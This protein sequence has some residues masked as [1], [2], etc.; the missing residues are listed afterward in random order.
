[1]GTTTR[2]R[3][4]AGVLVAVT[5]IGLAT[6]IVF[7]LR[8]VAP[9]V[10]LGVVYLLAVLLVA[11]VWGLW[12]GFA[13]AL[14]SALAFNFFHIPHTGRLTVNEGENWVALAVFLVAAAVSSSLAERARTR[15][16]EAE[17][18]RRE[19][20]LALELARLLLRGDD[21]KGSLP[22]ASQQLAAALGVTCEIVLRRVEPDGEHLVFALREGKR[23]LGTLLLPKAADPLVR[24]RV[25]RRIV[26]S[27]EALLAAA[28][29]R[30]ELLTDVV[31]TRALR[32]SD[33]VKTALLRAVSHDLRSPLTAILTAVEP[34]A[35]EQVE[36]ADRRELAR[37]VRDE[38]HRLSRLIDQLLDLSKLEADAADPRPEW[39]SVEEVVRAAMHDLG[40]A[41]D[42]F[43]VSLDKDTPLVR[44][45]A[46]QLERAFANVLENSLRYANGHPVLVRGGGT[47]NRVMVR[48]V[49]R[50]PGMLPAQAERI[51]EPFYRSGAEGTGHRGSGLGLAIARGFLEA[52]GGR[53]WAESQAGHETT[54]VIELPLAAPARRPAQ[55]AG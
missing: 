45:D 19:A 46:A 25:E 34:L 24:E 39:V 10:S 18:H 8:D 3:A 6:L 54:F 21:L 22:A 28:L 29:E 12:L 40:A 16:D 55:V 48:I 17:D 26:P 33:V 13:T 52:N 37:D 4:A 23:Q 11:S 1:M 27:L 50:G 31:E 20:D 44:A 41:D 2:S 32:H 53:I 36:D 42:A 9:V 7:P 43:R 30:D 14:A 51:F 5:S 38:A 15:A 49:D 47:H 35:G